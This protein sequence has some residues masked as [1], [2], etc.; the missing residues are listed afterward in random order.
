MRR[1]RTVLGAII[2]VLGLTGTTMALLPA[3]ASTPASHDV[4]VP[5]VPGQTVQVTWTGT[6]PP[7]SNPTNSC[8]AGATSDTHTV[9]VQVPPNLYQSLAATFSFKISWAPT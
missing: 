5:T 3:K 6:I 8:L 2:G 1:T 7:G 9:N 4:V